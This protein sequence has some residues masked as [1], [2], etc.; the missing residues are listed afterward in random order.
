MLIDIALGCPGLRESWAV[1]VQR[2]SIL[3]PE[4]DV[5]RVVDRIDPIWAGHDVTVS[6]TSCKE[7]IYWPIQ[8]E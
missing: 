5:D 6:G 4:K 2:L 7:V 1:D 3:R 8:R